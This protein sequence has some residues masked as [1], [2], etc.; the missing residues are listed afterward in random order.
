[1][2]GML[3]VNGLYKTFFPPLTSV[4][5]VGPS[6]RMKQQRE[7]SIRKWEETYATYGHSDDGASDGSRKRQRMCGGECVCEETGIGVKAPNT[8]SGGSDQLLVAEEDTNEKCTRSPTGGE[9]EI[10][11]KRLM[12]V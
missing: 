10:V 5:T 2:L 3:E 4:Q 12:S 8:I 1:M 9:N 6:R 11:I 7:E